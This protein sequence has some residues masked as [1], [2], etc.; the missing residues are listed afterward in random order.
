M[1]R[2]ILLLVA[3]QALAVQS[4]CHHDRCRHRHHDYK[5]GRHEFDG[6]FHE[7]SWA[8]V[9]ADRKAQRVCDENTNH[10]TETFY[11]NHYEISVSLPDFSEEEITVKIKH[12][13]IFIQAFKSNQKVFSEL[14]IVPEFAKGSNASWRFDEKVLNIY[15]P[16]EITLGTEVVRVCNNTIDESVITL[17]KAD[18][19]MRF[20]D[21][22][23]TVTPLNEDNL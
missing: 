2:I 4:G 5:N 14:K 6:E 18:I 20:G 15:V 13:V 16:Y 3:I 23:T 1:Y 10:S 21:D 12:R 19:D 11:S 9:R 17:P 7:L 22:E 8:V